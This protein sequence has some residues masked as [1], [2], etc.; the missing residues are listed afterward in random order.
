VLEIIA[1]SYPVGSDASGITA[2][3]VLRVEG[4]FQRGDMVVCRGA[5]GVELA[6]GL[7]NYSSQEI[8]KLR[9]QFVEAFSRQIGYVAEPHI[10]SHENLVV[11]AAR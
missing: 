9:G 3:M 10:I 11:H 4:V 2:L 7:V 8:Q 6:R 1:G 5:D